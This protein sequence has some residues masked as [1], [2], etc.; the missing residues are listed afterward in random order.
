MSEVNDADSVRK[1]ALSRL[2]EWSGQGWKVEKIRDII[3]AGNENLSNKIIEFEVAIQNSAELKKRIKSIQNSGLIPT[4]L[5]SWV[6]EL[7]DPLSFESINQEYTK[8][9]KQNRSW[10]ISLFNSLDSWLDLDLEQEYDDVLA[11]FD[12]LDI[13]SHATLRPYYSKLNNPSKL[14]EIEQML[15]MAETSERKQVNTIATAIENLE[16]MGIHLDLVRRLMM[17]YQIVNAEYLYSQRKIR[18]KD[19]ALQ[20]IYNNYRFLNFSDEDVRNLAGFMVSYAKYEWARR[21]LQPYAK[22]VDVDEEVLFYYLNLVQY[23]PLRAYFQSQVVDL[24]VVLILLKQ[25]AEQCLV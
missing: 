4:D 21:L 22:K 11:R 25:S 7:T 20:Y 13:S 23:K 12:D 16:K 1:L 5:D 10:E 24:E 2:N 3:D 19:Q 15:E 18:E 8:W 14:T 17:N 9:A 6:E